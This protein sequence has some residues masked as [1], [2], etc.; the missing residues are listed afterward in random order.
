MCRRVR[1]TVGLGPDN[2]LPFENTS[3]VFECY[4]KASPRKA[5]VGKA[6]D[7]GEGGAA[8]YSAEDDR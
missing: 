6:M 8:A 4:C 2:L 1:L 3:D 5:N 7:V